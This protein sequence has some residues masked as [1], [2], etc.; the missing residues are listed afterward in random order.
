GD[1]GEVDPGGGDPDQNLVRP[2]DRYRR[3]GDQPQVLRAVQ[4]RLLQGAH[5][6][7]D[8]HANLVP[9]HGL[10]DRAGPA[11]TQ[12]Y[13]ARTENQSL[14]PPCPS[15]PLSLDPPPTPHPHH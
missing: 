15:A 3:V 11:Y 12:E 7:G 10:R 6:S 9:F 1:S 14:T 5:G 4:G 13:P 8:A 2:R